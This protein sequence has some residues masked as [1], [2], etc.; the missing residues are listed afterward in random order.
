MTKTLRP[1]DK[2][3]WGAPQGPTKGVVE[4]K[5]TGVTKVKGHTARASKSDPHTRSAATR[6]APRRSISPRV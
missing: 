4:A 6:P 3:T 5:V 2:V 1:G